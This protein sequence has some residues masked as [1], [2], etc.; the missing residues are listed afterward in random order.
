MTGRLYWSIRWISLPKISQNWSNPPVFEAGR[1]VSDS[2]R[3][4]QAFIFRWERN[5]Q[6]RVLFIF[7]S[8]LVTILK[9]NPLT[10]KFHLPGMEMRLKW[11]RDVSRVFSLY[12]FEKFR[13]YIAA[14]NKFYQWG[15]ISWSLK[16][17]RFV[18]YLGR[19]KFSSF[20]MRQNIEQDATAEW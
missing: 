20:K 19:K 10:S 8:S 9:K 11:C 5:C 13:I 3:V 17:T 18:F 12:I 6:K 4:F 2:T 7:S 14:M 15:S 1:P 16:I